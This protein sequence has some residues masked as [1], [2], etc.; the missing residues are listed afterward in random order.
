MIDDESKWQTVYNQFYASPDGESPI[1]SITIPVIFTQHIIRAYSN[2]LQAKPH[3][4]LGGRLIQLL[5]NTEPDF[6]VSNSR[7]KVPLRRRT[8]IQVPRLTN[9]YRLKFEVARWHKEIAIVIEN[10]AE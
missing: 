6:E 5:G 1:G 10:Y 4:W 2:S 3:W 8:L 9:E 7:W